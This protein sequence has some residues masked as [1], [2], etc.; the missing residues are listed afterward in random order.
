MGAR[1]VPQLVERGGGPRAM[2]VRDLGQRTIVVHVLVD[3]CDAMGANLVNSIAE[4]IGPRVAELGEGKLGLRIL[5]NLCDRRRVRVTCRVHAKDLEVTS[6]GDTIDGSEV[7]DGIVEASRFAELDPYRAATHNKGIMNGVDAVVIATGNDFRAVE[8][9]AHAYAARSGRYCPLAIWRRDG[10]DLTGE[11]EMPLALGIVGGTLRVHPAARLALANHG[12][13]ELRGAQRNCRQRRAR[14]ES[15]SPSCPRHRGDPARAHVPACPRG[16]SCGRRNRG[17][18][19]TRRDGHRTG[20]QH[21]HRGCRAGVA[22]APRELG[23]MTEEHSFRALLRPELSELSAYSPEPG[24]FP[25][26]LDANEAPPLLSAAARERLGRAAAETRWERYPD[27]RASE[28]R[29][30]IARHHGVGVDEVLAGVGSDE[31]ISLLVTALATPRGKAPAP[32]L[33]T[34]TP[35]FVM[36]RLSARARGWSVMEVPLD[37]DW[38]LAEASLGRAIELAPPSLVF[39]ASPNNP[40]GTRPSIESLTRLVD[41]AGS[42]LTV[43]DEAY[44][45]YADG[46]CLAL[47]KHENVAIL[48]TLSKVGFASI[49]VGWILAHPA[50]VR[51]LDKVRLPYNLPS[52]SQR[53]ATLALTE[54]AEELRTNARHVVEERERLARELATIPGVTPTPS[55]A[56]FLWLRTARPAGE[57]FSGLKE[58]G[59]LVRSFHT[60]GGRLANQLRVTVGTRSE[61][62][63]FLSALREVA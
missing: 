17:R 57:V 7:I 40:T 31:V 45:D 49:R 21:Q 50:L 22:A 23:D 43:I 5:T 47:R 35:T 9:G 34:T 38:N 52:V 29:Q 60:R 30:A 28:L 2:E 15:R 24:E 14:L 36:Y 62:D 32:T 4:A 13:D 56:N 41:R 25:V 48:R 26:R 54:L 6:D 58:R 61:C 20:W 33:L 27:P 10:V 19:R 51:E 16:R 63:L 37:D 39:I 44:V 1:A 3:C 12:R 8:A 53:V 59:I 11:L 42:A 55:Q 46:D 18:G